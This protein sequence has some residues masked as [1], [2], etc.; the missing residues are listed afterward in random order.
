MKQRFKFIGTVAAGLIGILAASGCSAPTA[1]PPAT[2]QTKTLRIATDDEPGRPAAAQI[3]EF[4]RQVKELS[5]GRVLIEPVWKAVGEDKDD[6]DQAVARGVIAGDF[7]MGLI[8]ARAWDTEGVSSFAALH[9]PFLVTSNALMAKVAEPAIADEML[10]GLDKV[11]VSGLA[12]FPEGTRMLFSFRGPVLKPSDLAGKTVRAPRSDTTYA[13]LKAFG[14]T[15]DDLVGDAFPEGVAAGEVVAA[16]SSFLGAKSLPQPTT[17]AANVV[18]YSKLNSLVANTHSFQALSEAQRQALQD[19]A[20]ATR[21][22]AAD[23]MTTSADDAANFCKDGGTVVTAT[24]NEL[25]A[26]KSAGA[27]VYAKLEADPETKTR[28]AKIRELRAGEPAPAAIK[29]CSPGD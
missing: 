14:A 27:P 21:T 10:G 13:L 29:P 22:W 12:L 2:E 5:G 9:A 7:D 19:A 25:A 4:S 16:E 20:A 15:P 18:L 23:A 1:S 17:A 24:E 11:G 3:E 6:W 8:P 28:I 26:F